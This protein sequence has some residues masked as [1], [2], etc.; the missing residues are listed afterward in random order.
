MQR[1]SRFLHKMFSLAL[2]CF[3]L[4]QQSF[5][6][7]PQIALA[8]GADIHRGIT[9]K[10]VEQKYEKNKSDP[11][12]AKAIRDY[13]D[14]L[15]TGNLSEDI[16]QPF[17]HKYFPGMENIFETYYNTASQYGNTY[18]GWEMLG[19]ATHLAQ[20]MTTPDHVHGLHLDN[21]KWYIPIYGFESWEAE[22]WPY[23]L[24]Q[25]VDENY[26]AGDPS[27]WYV[28]IKD[29]SINDVS[30]LD[31]YLNS[32][33]Y[34]LY[35]HGFPL[36]PPEAIFRTWMENS[37]ANA[38]ASTMGLIDRFWDD[39]TSGGG[40]SLSSPGGDRPDDSSSVATTNTS[41]DPAEQDYQRRIFSYLRLGIKKGKKNLVEQKRIIGEIESLFALPPQPSE[42]LIKE[43]EQRIAFLAGILDRDRFTTENDFDTSP[44]IAV[45][46]RGF[47]GELLG[48]IDKYNEPVKLIDT[49]FSPTIAKDHP[50]FIIPTGGLY[51]L[52]SSPIFRAK[53]EE[54]VK[55]GGSLIV[56]SQQR[57]YEFKALPGGELGGYGWQEDMSCQSNS[58]EIDQYHQVLASQNASSSNISV[59][60][61]FT[62]WPRDSTII[63]RRTK[64]GMPAMLTYPYGQGRV[65]ATTSYADW[66]YGMSQASTSEKTLVRDLISWAK[67]PTEIPEYRPS[68]TVRIT[69]N[70]KNITDKPT[71]TVE[72]KLLSPDRNEIHAESLTLAL[73]PGETKQL[74]F[75]HTAP[76]FLGIYFVDY[77]LKDEAG[78]IVQPQA[79]GERFSVS[80]PPSG[81]VAIP[82]ILFSVQSDAERYA[83]GSNATFVVNVWNRGDIPKNITVWYAFP[84]SFLGTGNPIYGNSFTLHPGLTS[85]L[86]QTLSVAPNSSSYFM[87]TVPAVLTAWG[88]DR[89]F[90]DFYDENGLYLGQST[91]AFYVF[92]P[93]VD[94]KITPNKD[95]YE[96]GE[97]VALTLDLKNKQSG[98]Y[99]SRVDISVA[100]PSNTKVF[101]QN[102][103]VSLPASGTVS[104]SLGFGF[105]SAAKY[106]IYLVRAEAYGNGKKIGSSSSS[107]E[108]SPVLLKINPQLPSYLTPNTTNTFSFVVENIG[109][110]NSSGA[111]LSAS[112]IG[113][114]GV[115][116][117]SE[118]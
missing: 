99:T 80:S 31:Y 47:F 65:I 13:R 35:K 103:S 15:A 42:S 1:K 101:E 96:T 14:V 70:I 2:A 107:F 92:E 94:I 7:T 16:S 3:L 98:S 21:P 87:I 23:F 29:K 52:D 48:L 19:R 12:F 74:D 58:V 36:D 64:N 30:Y 39:V 50:I 44:D 37:T 111:K 34:D 113:P 115:T 66:A 83:A 89:L 105:P 56:F 32:F 17:T 63:L 68:Q 59:D 118:S 67:N 51:G 106:G 46:K 33:K 49:D 90:A 117:W 102:L 82:D 86:K 100:D 28:N 114:G 88:F 78:N 81:T 72:L 4:G 62:S 85:N 20:D 104:Q 25:N 40:P 109:H 26:P 9:E 69:E 10:A 55:N 93:S 91:R 43:R 77:V 108:L 112:L 61:F 60:G 6:F 97:T 84:Y 22:Q 73:A 71:T 53:L 8:H 38:L 24:I 116:V 76:T 45:L 18:F 41:L 11:A 75:V 57:G 5:L 54:Y 79:E 27:Q 95:R 110:A